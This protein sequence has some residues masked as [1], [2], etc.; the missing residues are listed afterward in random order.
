MVL[1][2]PS[3]EF[4]TFL[5]VLD[6]E[7]VMWYLTYPRA[8]YKTPSWLFSNRPLLFVLARTLTPLE[9]LVGSLGSPGTID[10]GTGTLDHHGP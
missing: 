5:T 1:Y 2:L 4:H 6:A 8:Y 7:F 10:R 3:S 9:A